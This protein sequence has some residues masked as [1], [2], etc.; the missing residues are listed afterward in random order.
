MQVTIPESESALTPAWFSEVLSIEQ[1]GTTVNSVQREPIGVGAGMMSGLYRVLLEYASGSGPASVVVKL[2]TGNVQNREVAVTFD[3]YRREVEFYRRAA[4][5]T[6]MRTPRVYLAEHTGPDTFVLVLEDLSSWDQGDQ[7]VGCELDRAEAVMDALAALHGSFWGQVDGDDMQWLPDTY[8]SVM[9]DG[10]ASGT[11]ASWEDFVHVFD[12]MLP[13]VLKNAKQPYLSGL[14]RVQQAINAA[15]RTIIHGD[16]RMD[17]LFFRPSSQGLEVA[18]CDWQAP[19]RGKGIHDVAYFLSG[20]IDTAMRREHEKALLQRWLRSLSAQGIADY[21]EEQAWQDY[22]LAILMLWTYVVV[23]GG[24]LAA[25]NDRG[26][27]WVTAMVERSAAAMVDHDC[28]A[29]LE[30]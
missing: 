14:P 9:S 18:C 26:T 8:P 21:S 15:P 20:S 12:D 16:F 23:V 10:L 28:L 13:D 3:N 4:H 5:A 25:D 22:R 19:V 11:E 17:N 6:P 2:P 29:L 7:I 30:R 1:P 24:G 27:S